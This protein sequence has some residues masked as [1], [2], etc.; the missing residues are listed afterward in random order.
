MVALV[1]GLVLACY[2]PALHG[3]LV[4]DDNA[5]VTRPDLR[6]WTGLGRIWFDVRATQQY[7]P[8]LHSAFWIEHRLWGDA[9]LGYHLM[10][11]FL[12]VAACCLFA[13]VLRRLWQPNP[14]VE[15]SPRDRAASGRV[16]LRAAWL[17]AVVFAVHP[18]CVESVAWISEQKNTMSLVFYLLAA[19]AYLDFDA[20]RRRL[21]Y[22]L[23]SGFFFL[24]LATKTVTASLPAAI[25]VVLWWR[26]GRLSWKR[27]ARPL[28]PWFILAMMAAVVTI[29]IEHSIIGAQ[30]AK[31]DLS[32]GQRVLLAGRVI[33]FYLGKLAWPSDLMFIYPRWIVPAASAGWYAGLVVALAVT[34]TF[35]LVRRRTRGLL[36][37]WLFFVGSLFPALGFFNVYPFIFSYVADHFQYLAS[38]G[39]IATVA[40]GVATIL[41]RASPWVHAGGR[42]LCALVVAGFA[43]M[44]NRQSGLYSGAENLYRQTLAQNPSCWMAHNN[45]GLAL[46]NIP[47]RI[48]EA[49]AHYEEALRLNPDL[50]EA[51]I[52]LGLALSNIPGRLPDAISQYEAAL[53]INPDLAEGY[54]HLGLALSGIPGRLPEAISNYET[55]LRISPELA[56]AHNNLGVALTSVPGRLPDAI[57]QF[58][59]ALRIDPELAGTH[60]NLGLALSGIPGRTPEAI[61]HF[62]SALRINP[63]LAEAHN[64]LGLALSGIPG[65]LP[66]AVSHFE[67]A[68]RINPDYA[69][70]HNNLGMALGESPDRVTE[71]IAHYEQ[72]LRLQPDFAEAQIN[73]AHELAKQPG[74][75]AEAIALYEQVLQLHPRLAEVH[76]YLA[77]ALAKQPDHM[78]EARAHFEEALQ[79]RPDY[80]EAHNGLGIVLACQGQL[81]DARKEWERALQLNPNFKEARR[82]LDLLKKLKDPRSSDSP[83]GE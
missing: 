37:G 33:W 66:E 22:G 32:M 8:V 30:G 82:N 65:R 74:R 59:A 27:D 62:E 68:L 5:H 69:R 52:N 73:L 28:I 6:S 57:S 79:I 29:S 46:A 58:Q 18:I 77:D 11:V 23:A 39:I 75:R 48:P 34:V 71:A 7:Y 38:L 78:A 64:N 3:G 47:G 36:A 43:L 76:M 21:S 54:N 50:A 45:L 24:A 41:T 56:E 53:R 1:F 72:A 16:P 10:N 67:A 63:D 55:A 70:A 15:R 44:S 19:L 51:H 12:H 60:L 20:R 26:N 4:W 31:F 35:W 2:W 61:A 81:D 9:A 40:A 17:A 49:I 83:V 80:V 14:A 13:L 25:L 42:L